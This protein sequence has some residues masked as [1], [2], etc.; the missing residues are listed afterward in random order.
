MGISWNEITSRAIAFSKEWCDEKYEN[1][2]A[3]S[4][5]DDFF[6]VFGVDRR[7]VARFEK[8]IKKEDGKNGFT[9][10][11]SNACRNEIKRKKSR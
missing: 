7:R 4:Y 11:R 8:K 3:K 2:E 9:L 1:G 10:E 5:L 6:H